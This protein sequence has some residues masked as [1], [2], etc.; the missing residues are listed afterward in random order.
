MADAQRELPPKM[1][2][3]MLAAM[4]SG[5]P[6]ALTATMKKYGTPALVDEAYRVALAAEQQQEESAGPASEATPAD[7]E[8]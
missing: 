8:K 5:G 6:E 7:A 1:I 4:K 3:E 2:G